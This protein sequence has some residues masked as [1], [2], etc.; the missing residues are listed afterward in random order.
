[1]PG[2]AA[3]VLLQNE[4]T[5]TANGASTNHLTFLGLAPF[6]MGLKSLFMDTRA[7]IQQYFKNLYGGDWESLLADN[8]VFRNNGK[9][10]PP[11][12]T[13]YIEATKRFL[14][15]AKSVEVK[16]LIVEG[17]KACA[18]TRYA[19]LSPTGKTG[20]CDVAELFAVRNG[21]IH[22]NSIIFDMLA[23]HEFTAKG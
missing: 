19:L 15:I 2:V 10:N 18:V 5:W 13:T 22:S 6:S 7:V 8:M 4:G 17:D 11:G 12:K 21:K 20:V 9:K 14:H 3:C 23:F 1:M 16:E